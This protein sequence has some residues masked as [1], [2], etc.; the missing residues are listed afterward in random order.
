MSK[1]YVIGANSVDIEKIRS[2]LSVPINTEIIVVEKLSDLPDGIE[3][4]F[5]VKDFG[6]K[7]PIDPMPLIEPFQTFNEKRKGHERPYKY[8][9]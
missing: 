2:R 7:I 1:V 4:V 3:E 8:H 5:H 9:K 6:K